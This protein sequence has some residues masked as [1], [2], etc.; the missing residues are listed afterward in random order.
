MRHF[1]ASCPDCHRLWLVGTSQA[2][3]A[4]PECP[5]CGERGRLV[6][7]AYY[8]DPGASIFTRLEEAVENTQLSLAALHELSCELERVLPSPSEPA[9]EATFSVTMTRLGL[10]GDFDVKAV[11]KRVALRMLVTIT[12]TLSQP[13]VK[14]SGVMRL[15]QTI[16]GLFDSV[17]KKRPAAPS[18]GAPA[19]DGDNENES[20]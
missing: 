20:R 15:P 16:P 10:G 3:S 14:E 9:I 12:G 18:N 5:R 19:L 6:P 8:S 7:G 1:P 4:S 11:G 2:P 17:P 13:A